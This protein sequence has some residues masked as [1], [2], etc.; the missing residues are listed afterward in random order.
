MRKYICLVILLLIS[1]L[2]RSHAQ[3]TWTQQSD[4]GGPAIADAV[5]FAI[6]DKGYVGT[7]VGWTDAGYGVAT[8]SFREYDPSTDTWTRKAHV[9]GPPQARVASAAA[10]SIGS[11]GYIGTGA[12]GMGDDAHVRD[13]LEYDPVTDRWTRKADFGGVGRSGAVGFPIGDKGYIGLGFTGSVVGNPYLSDLW[14]Y[15]PASDTWTQK[16][17]FPG[18]KTVGA[19]GFSIGNKGYV[20]TGASRGGW[21]KD[22]WEYDPATDTWTQKA[23][24]GGDPIVSAVGFAIN[25]KGYI[26]VGSDSGSSFYI[27]FWEYDP[28][29]DTW[30]QVADFP[31][32]ARSGAVAFAIGDHGYLGIGAHFY[33]TAF[34][35]FWQ[36]TP[37]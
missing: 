20:G 21:Q 36:F 28:T 16:A 19:V 11:K 35:D 5:G 18:G 7:G 25:G 4:F 14:E 2:I 31:G 8:S 27:G 9:P 33:P 32:I 26:G 29:I 1:P 17:D 22:F 34:K 13:F 24:Y 30:T 10:F 3:G 6:G 37:Q 23:D 15:D 12:R